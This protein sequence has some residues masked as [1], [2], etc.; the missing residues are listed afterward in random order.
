MIFRL[1][2]LFLASF[3]KQSLVEGHACRYILGHWGNSRTSHKVPSQQLPKRIYKPEIKF[4][5]IFYYGTHERIKDFEWNVHFAQINM[6]SYCMDTLLLLNNFCFGHRFFFFT[7]LFLND[8]FQFILIPFIHC[9]WGKIKHDINTLR[10]E[11]L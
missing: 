11:Y 10:T 3:L 8:F 2:L 5:H 7:M 9:I 6:L 4:S 1:W